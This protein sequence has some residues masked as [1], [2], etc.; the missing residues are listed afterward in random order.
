MKTQGIA[1]VSVVLLATLGI[2]RG[3][4]RDL[5][6]Q[7]AES[8]WTLVWSD[9]FNGP[10]GSRPDAAKWKFEVGGNGWGNQE[11]Q[12]YTTRPENSFIRGGNLVIQTLQENFAGTDRV[13]RNYTSA[14]M[15]TQGLFEQAY[16]RFEAR[17][18]V[19]RGQGIWPAFWLLGN[20]FGKVGWPACGEID[21]MENIGKEP[22]TIHGS[23]HG[24]G[25]SGDFDFT[26]VYK[27]PG[28][29]NFFDDFHVF[30]IEWEPGTVRFYVDQELYSTF[31]PSRLPAGRKWVFDHPFFIV[32]NVAVGGLWP[33]LPD[34]TTVFPQAMLVD[35]VRVYKAH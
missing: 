23:M 16:G 26:S 10:D 18:K 33:G 12:Y 19:P 8:R 27:L 31:T 22:S 17:V 7:A 25:Y 21:I 28:G 34:S 29:V 13:A 11:L 6:P 14:R 15:T 24:P 4:G 20:D 9:E 5:S 2:C 1:F 35:Y 3:T 30:A 32:L